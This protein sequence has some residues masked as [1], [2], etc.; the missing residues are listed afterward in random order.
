VYVVVGQVVGIIIHLLEN[1]NH[2]Y[3]EFCC[4]HV[5]SVI[6]VVCIVSRVIFV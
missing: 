1:T 6:H 4:C 5:Q 2:F 3:H